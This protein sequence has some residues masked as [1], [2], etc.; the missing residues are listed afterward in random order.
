MRTAY[1]DLDD[2]QLAGFT[3]LRQIIST[4]KDLK[5][6]IEVVEKQPESGVTSAAKLPRGC[7]CCMESVRAAVKLLHV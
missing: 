2:V 6:K 5:K 3:Q 7:W 1:R 4:H